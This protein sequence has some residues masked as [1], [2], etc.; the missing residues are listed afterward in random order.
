MSLLFAK[1]DSML[2]M[3]ELAEKAV[4]ESASVEAIKNEYDTEREEIGRWIIVGEEVARRKI[5]EV[6]QKPKTRETMG[7]RGLTTP[8]RQHNFGSENSTLRSLRSY[9]KDS[10]DSAYEPSQIEEAE[11]FFAALRKTR[12]RREDFTER[13][14]DAE[15]VPKEN[16]VPFYPL[17]YDIEK[18]AKRLYK[19]LPF[20]KDMSSL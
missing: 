4:D 12:K 17:L 13:S 20:G 7:A 15:T 6:L 1:S 2:K 11:N 9:D 18:G 10:S 14:E 3:Y 19:N 16:P 8:G 5:E